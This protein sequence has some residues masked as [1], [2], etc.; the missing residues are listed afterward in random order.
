MK[1]TLARVTGVVLLAASFAFCG[2]LAYA[3]T[4][5]TTSIQVLT[6]DAVGN[7]GEIV[8]ALDCDT[9][10][11]TGNCPVDITVA[12]ETPATETTIADAFDP[13]VLEAVAETTA[14]TNE[15]AI[16]SVD[17]IIAEVNQTVVIVV[18]GDTDAAVE[19]PAQTATVAEPA[20]TAAVAAPAAEPTTEDKTTSDASASQPNE[21]RASEA[22]AAV[23]VEVTQSV[24][25]AVPGQAV[26]DEPVVTG[27][28]TEPLSTTPVSMLDGK[29]CDEDF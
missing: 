24:T 4:E 9:G 10:D 6:F 28:I 2:S 25:V 13:A 22:S 20:H 15:P 18:T 7:P 8:A 11:G 19:E 1:N 16:R 26:D 17:A 5:D 27:S 29:N 12:A 3:D 23:V 14:D 21:E